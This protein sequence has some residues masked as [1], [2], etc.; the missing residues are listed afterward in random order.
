MKEGTININCPGELC[1]QPLEYNEIKEYAPDKAFSRCLSSSQI[2]SDSRYDEL[3]C[4]KAYEEDPNFRWC[5]NRTCSTGQ[6]IDD[7][8]NPPLPTNN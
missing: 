5:T 2:K 1:P 3:L 7:G 4:R 8:G 6:I